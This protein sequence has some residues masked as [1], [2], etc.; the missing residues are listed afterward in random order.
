MMTRLEDLRYW[1]RDSYKQIAV[2]VR[3]RILSGRR[4][5]QSLKQPIRAESP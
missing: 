2:C 3:S 5:A 4:K 1:F